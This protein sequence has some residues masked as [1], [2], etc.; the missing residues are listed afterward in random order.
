[1]VTK[2]KETKEGRDEEECNVMD[3]ECKV[4]GLFLAIVVC[5]LK[6]GLTMF[7]HVSY[8]QHANNK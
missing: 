5:N 2:K 8:A 7:H 3:Q 6:D 4:H 1:M